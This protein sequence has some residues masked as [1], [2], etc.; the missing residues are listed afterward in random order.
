MG[1]NYHPRI[2]EIDRTAALK[3]VLPPPP[4]PSPSLAR[5]SHGNCRSYN[6]DSPAQ[7]Q[8]QDLLGDVIAFEALF[9][10]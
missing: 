6:L 4:S 8:P 2:E 5:I 3:T 9:G 1:V 7:A 10:Q